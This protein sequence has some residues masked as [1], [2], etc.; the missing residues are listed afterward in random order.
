VS[1]NAEVPAVPTAV[2]MGSHCAERVSGE[3]LVVATVMAQQEPGMWRWGSMVA[4][5]EYGAR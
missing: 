3:W 1:W 2:V 4:I 5:E